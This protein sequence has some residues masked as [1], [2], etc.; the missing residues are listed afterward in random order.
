MKTSDPH[1]RGYCRSHGHG[2]VDA[3]DAFIQTRLFEDNIASILR[4]ESAILC[5][6]DYFFCSLF[7]AHCCVGL[8]GALVLSGPIRLGHLLIA[9]RHGILIEIC[10]HCGGK[11]LITSFTGNIKDNSNRW[12]G[13]CVDCKEW[14]S[15]SSSKND[16]RHRFQV[17]TR[18]LKRLPDQ[19]EELECY[20]GYEFAW[21][22]DG[23]QPA[24]RK[25]IATRRLYSVVPFDVLVQQLA[26]G[27]IRKGCPPVVGLS[28]DEFKRKFQA[29][30]R[31]C[32]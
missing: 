22:G 30:P 25:R 19:F 16:F 23:L 15:A 17:A 7:V 6:S 9:W 20:S 28:Q 18:I 10:R 11:V 29:L 3:Y 31:N 1:V 12:H 5:C 26:S 32:S 24:T 2:D 14:L 4:Q 21:S 8:P 13:I 27:L